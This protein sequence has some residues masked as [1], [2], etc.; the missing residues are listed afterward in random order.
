MQLDSCD[1]ALVGLDYPIHTTMAGMKVPAKI[2]AK[3]NA[4]M[5]LPGYISLSSGHLIFF[6]IDGS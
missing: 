4:P 6:R 5:F 1:V 2:T 3:R